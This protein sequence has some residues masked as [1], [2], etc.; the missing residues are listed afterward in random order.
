MEGGVII[1]DDYLHWD[2]QRRA[3]DEFFASKNIKYDFVDIGNKKT[4]AII[5]KYNK[6]LKN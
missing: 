1:F 3:T 2:G 4:T 6:I 5:K